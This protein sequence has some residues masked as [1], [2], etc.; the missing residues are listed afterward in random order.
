MSIA[1]Y[2]TEDGWTLIDEVLSSPGRGGGRLINNKISYDAFEAGNYIARTNTGWNGAGVTGQSAEVT[3]SFPTWEGI[4]YN[5]A[6][7]TGLRG[8][9]EYQKDQARLSLQSW[10][11]VAN[12]TFTE[13]EAGR[14]EIYTNITF[15]YISDK[16]TQAYA[17]RPHTTDDYGRPYTDARGFDVSGQS[18]YSSEPG[19]LNVTPVAGNYGRLTFTHEIGHTLGLNHPGN[20]NAGQGVPSYK[21]ADY[22]EDTRQYSVMSYWSEK[23]TGADHKGY[24]A[25]APLLDDITAIQKLYGANYHTRTGDTIYGFD[26]NTGRD[27]YSAKSVSDKLI[28]TVWDGG[29]ND[30]LNFSRYKQDQKI[31]LREG[32]FSD[33]GGLTGNVSIAHGVKIENAY[34]GRGNDVIIGNDENNILK[35]NGGDDVLYGGAGQDQLWGGTGNDIFVFSAVTDSLYDHPDH[36]HDF[37]TGLDMIDLQGL[38]QNRDGEKF[39]YFTDKFTGTAGEAEL[40]Y[41]EGLNLTELLINI[42][43]DPCNYDFRVDITGMVNV[44]TDFIV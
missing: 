26:S 36:I 33:V 19:A 1:A 27:Y 22:A 2:G 9:N 4:Y 30:T 20:Y 21:D 8:F 44:H 37:S 43:G 38:N 5:A 11:D 40:R 24:Y 12:I 28:F 23:I 35:G 34:G 42:S 32:D 10:A 18:W 7:N 25:S 31:S 13:V 29:G 15:G 41:D 3:Y 16:Y 14:G 17:W 39:I 6:G